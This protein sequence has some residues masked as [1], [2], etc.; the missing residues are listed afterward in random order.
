M[1]IAVISKRLTSNRERQV[2]VENPDPEVRSCKRAEN[3]FILSLS[4]SIPH[5]LKGIKSQS[6]SIV[7]DNNSNNN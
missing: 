1:L 3:F 5:R 2:A 7:L 4:L 6:Y